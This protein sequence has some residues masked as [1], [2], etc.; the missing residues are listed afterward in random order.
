MKHG[1]ENTGIA[2]NNRTMISI[3]II[4]GFVVLSVIYC[5]PMLREPGIHK[6]DDTTFHV[7]R[8]VGLANVW[9]SPVNYD[10]FGHNGLMVNIFYPWLTVYP[11]RMLYRLTGAYVAAYKLYHLLLTAATLI[12]AYLSMHGITKSR[13]SSWVFAVLYA[14][15][16]YRFADVYNRDSLG[17]AIALTFLPLMLLGLYKIC[18]EN[19][20]EWRKL[21]AGMVLI[22]YS[23]ILSLCMSAAFVGIVY[24]FTLLF[25][26]NRR[27]RF[28]AMVKAAALSLGLTAAMIVPMLEQFIR[29]DLF[30]PEGG[31]DTL[32]KSSYSLAEIIR[33]TLG[34]NPAG[35]GI[36]MMS[37]AALL[38]A[39]ILLA[40]RAVR[41]R[42][43]KQS[44]DRFAVWMIV[45]G[46]IIF[47]CTADILPWQSLGD[48]TPVA[49]LQFV[50]RLNAYP[51]LAFA[52]AVSVLISRTMKSASGGVII[53]M[54]I[55]VL[56]AAGIQYYSLYTQN[57]EVVSNNYIAE[58][59]VASWASGNVDY[60]PYQAR[61]YRDAHEG[62]MEYILLDG[63]EIKKTPET[64]GRGTVYSQDL[65]GSD[66]ERT[67]DIPVFRYY[68]ENVLIN[69]EPADAALSVRGTTEI[70]VPPADNSTVTISYRYTT[71]ARIAWIASVIICMLDALFALRNKDARKYATASDQ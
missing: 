20:R 56:A 18:F 51:V 40:G 59:D 45:T 42:G 43:I 55:A 39:V 68:G 19:Y 30:T 54:G 58:E 69:G 60:A 63:E 12:I 25:Q 32:S 47:V 37:A 41:N 71:L 52:A 36:G 9:S 27:G 50:W 57:A 35:R 49:T 21:T 67:A 5:I 29:N 1:R 26:D 13:I 70:R 64:S 61:E 4:A 16:S 7:G 3:L 10:S 11:M 28:M 34:N 65:G 8:L 48:N 14:F 2:N 31:G 17:E 33:F 23:H 46:M 44:C 15:S 22:A 24:L 38:V 53:L 62:N 66:A 6:L